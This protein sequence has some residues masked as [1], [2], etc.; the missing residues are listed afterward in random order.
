MFDPPPFQRFRVGA[1]ML[2]VVIVMAVASA[3]CD[4]AAQDSLK[5]GGAKPLKGFKEKSVL[6]AANKLQKREL[7]GMGMKREPRDRQSSESKRRLA[8]TDSAGSPEIR[9]DLV[10]RAAYS[11]VQPFRKQD[12]KRLTVDLPPKYSEFDTDFDGQ[13]AL[14]EWMVARRADMLLFDR[15]DLDGDGLL[16]PRELAAYDFRQGYV[17]MVEFYAE[18]KSREAEQRKQAESRR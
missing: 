5:P 12:G 3:Q 2:P 7:K 16:T 11:P 14:Y 6:K 13:I 9:G 18:K 4:V 15:M 17:R 1:L 10:N 8:A